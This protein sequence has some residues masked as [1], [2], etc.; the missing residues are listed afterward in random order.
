[1]TNSN[2]K[3][4]AFFPVK[5]RIEIYE[6]CFSGHPAASFYGS[7]P[8]LVVSVGDYIVEKAWEPVFSK[9]L[10]SGQTLRVKGI[11]HMLFQG[12]NDIIHSLGVCVEIVDR[13]KNLYPQ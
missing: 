8:F 4:D 12:K 3:G 6:D 1:M 7:T 11:E 13:P 9:K 5:Y 10:K 2:P